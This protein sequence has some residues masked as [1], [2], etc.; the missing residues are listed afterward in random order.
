[1]GS[2]KK[3]KKKQR[4]PGDQTNLIM[5][6][7]GEAD[8][9]VEEV[10]ALLDKD[11]QAL[12]GGNLAQQLED[13]QAQAQTLLSNI[14]K[15]QH[16]RAIAEK[17]KVQNC[18]HC[19]AQLTTW[20][21]PVSLHTTAVLEKVMVTKPDGTV[22]KVALPSKIGGYSYVCYTCNTEGQEWADGETE[23]VVAAR[24]EELEALHRNW[25]SSSFDGLYPEPDHVRSNEI[26]GDMM[27]EVKAEPK[28]KARVPAPVVDEVAGW[29]F[30]A[31]GLLSCLM[32]LE[33]FQRTKKKEALE[34]LSE[35]LD[36]ERT[37]NVIS[38]EEHK[39][40]VD[41]LGAIN[42]AVDEGGD[43]LEEAGGLYGTLEGLMGR[44]LYHNH[45]LIDQN[46]VVLEPGDWD[47][48]AG[49][50][51]FSFT[52]RS[53]PVVVFKRVETETP[54]EAPDKEEEKPA[55]GEA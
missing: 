51:M 50:I 46:E 53:G 37:Q 16:K 31:R 9:E 44:V 17:Q 32:E 55:D 48:D 3:G 45:P 34:A 38:E 21:H 43:G 29:W 36:E 33:T 39:R 19:G 5:A 27:D 42:K 20:D 18:W 41:A 13:Q 6:V 24:K 54:E 12:M 30:S 28:T 14:Q 15:A 1:M 22:S 49:N 25:T 11:D 2:S 26:E 7:K 47:L 23:K 40:L 35:E 52:V 4:M 8:D 10:Q